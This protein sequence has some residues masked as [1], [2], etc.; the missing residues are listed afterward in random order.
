MASPFS[1]VRDRLLRNESS[2]KRYYPEASLTNVWPVAVFGS[3]PGNKKAPAMPEPFSGEQ[4]R[5]TP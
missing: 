1:F 4:A 5:L 2:G 3:I